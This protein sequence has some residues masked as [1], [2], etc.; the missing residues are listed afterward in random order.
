MLLCQLLDG[1]PIIACL[2]IL[3]PDYGIKSAAANESILASSK[4]RLI[5]LPLSAALTGDTLA[6]FQRCWLGLAWHG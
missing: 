4:S 3:E 1:V 6:G 5:Q 2:D